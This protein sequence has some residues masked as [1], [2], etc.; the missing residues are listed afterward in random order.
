MSEEA[1][2]SWYNA[3]IRFFHV[4][5]K[6]L[7]FLS[8]RR[9]FSLIRRKAAFLRG[10]IMSSSGRH[11]VPHFPL[12]Y[13]HKPYEGGNFTMNF[14]WL[15]PLLIGAV[16][17]YI[18]NDIAIKMLFH[19]RKAY[20]IGKWRVPFTPGLIPKEKNRVAHS[21]GN[22]IS[23][24]L[25]NSDVVIETLTS[26]HMVAEIRG[27]LIRIVEDNRDNTDKVRDVLER[28]L[29][30]EKTEE[31][32]AEAKRRGTELIYCK[33]ISIRFGESIS[34]VILQ[35]IK[36]H[37][38]SYVKTFLG[39]ILD[40]LSGSVADMIDQVVAN[41]SEEVIRSIIDNEVDKIE[42]ARICDLIEKNEEKL[43]EYIESVI[44]MYKTVIT[45]H[46]KT[47]L[48]GVNLAQ[49]VEE[50]VK[51]FDVVQLENMIF[52]IMD[53]ELKAIVYLGALLGCLMGAI[54]I[55]I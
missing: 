2:Y 52:G 48:E 24:Q 47:I 32:L 14:N 39:G 16:I 4:I 29:G 34:K 10:V 13:W 1:G 53:K 43:P 11:M 38:N 22:V 37:Q 18:T 44:K 55:F 5:K 25:L 36:E 35:K 42:N 46:M 27:K 45:N 50:R 23:T 54:N 41:N 28:I 40:E 15:I 33:L 20:Y 26:D 7:M 8:R 12:K 21:I 9:V 51:S 3:V 31:V 17:G 30:T 6:A 49:I 19:P